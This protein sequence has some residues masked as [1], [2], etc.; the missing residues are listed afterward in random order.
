[1]SVKDGKVASVMC[2]YNRVNGPFACDNPYTLTEVLRNQ[3]GFTGYVQSDFGATHSTATSLNAGEDFEM[4]SGTFYSAARINAALAD[5]SLAMATIDRALTRR[6]VQMFKFGI[7]DRPIT[8]GQIDA[9][10][11]GQTA[12]SI[13]EQTA[14]L[15][16]NQGGLLPLN[17]GSIHSI[18]LIGQSTY[19]AAAAAGGGGSS[20]VVPLYTVTPLQGLQ[21]VLTS[22]GSTATVTLLTVP[23]TPTSANLAAVTAAASSADVVIVVAGVVTSEGSDR[24][25]LSLPTNQDAIIT[26]VAAANNPRTVLVLKDGDP[27]LMPWVDQIPAILEAWNPGEEDGNVVARL[28]FGLVNPSGK[29]PVTYP[30]LATDTPTS[31]PDRYPG[32]TIGGVPTATYSEG[33]QMG[34][35]WYDAQGIAPLFPFG[36]GLSYTTFAYGNVQVTP[37]VTDGK[38]PITVQLTVTN[39]GSRAGADVPQVY[40]GFQSPIGEPPKRLVAFQKVTLNP[41]EQ[42]LVT[43]TIDPNANSHPISTWDTASQKWGLAHGKLSVYLARSAGDIASS[44]FATVVFPSSGITGDVNGDGVVNCQDLMALKLAFGIR[45]GEAGYLPTAD[46]DGNGVIDVNDMVAVTRRMASC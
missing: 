18:A 11:N 9:V 15:L 8:R 19:A 27:V 29:L 6:Y 43:M 21:N 23:N 25:S 34:Y 35:R 5:G 32:I 16:K 22:L 3:W 12:R 17:A 20:R 26:A 4:Q 28:L 45:A 44:A 1:M 46:V 24:P 38:S 40:V 14:V 39:T 36:H 42:K 33:L 2:S 10:T 7:F 13:A 41:G 37:A 31:T 30:K